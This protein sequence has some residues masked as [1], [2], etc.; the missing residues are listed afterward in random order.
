MAVVSSLSRMGRWRGAKR[1]DGGALESGRGAKEP[2]H[3]YADP[4]PDFVR[5]ETVARFSQKN[6]PYT[7]DMS[8]F[9][10]QTVI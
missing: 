5:E 3:R 7:K 8:F 9:L 2:L 10:S 6:K 1:R 4:L